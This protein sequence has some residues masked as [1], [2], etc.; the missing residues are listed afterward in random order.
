V[1]TSR[2]DAHCCLGLHPNIELPSQTEVSFIE[3]NK[4][5]PTE[6]GFWNMLGGARRGAWLNPSRML[7][8]DLRRRLGW[9]LDHHDGRGLAAPGAAGAAANDGGQGKASNDHEDHEGNAFDDQPADCG[10]DEKA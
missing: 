8:F 2:F 4:K 10:Q 1:N 5:I 3:L 9:R 6:S 7:P